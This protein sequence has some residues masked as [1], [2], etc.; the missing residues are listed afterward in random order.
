MQKRPIES[1]RKASI[2]LLTL[3]ILAAT[4]KCARTAEPVA[5]AIADIRV[6]FAGHYKLGHWTPIEMLLSAGE[7]AVQGDVE[8]IVPDGD[9]VPTRVV[10]R[11]VALKAGEKRWVRLCVKF[12]RPHAAIAVEFR[13]ADG[14][15]LAERTF[16]G[17][18]VPV[19]LGGSS[20]SGAAKLV[21]EIGSQ[22]DLGSSIR[23]SDEGEPEETAV[24]YVDDPAQLPDRWDGYDG[25]DLVVLTTSKP[26]FYRRLSV[27]ALE[28]SIAG[29]TS[30][31]AW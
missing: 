16:S 6:G 2:L 23:F 29:C 3:T 9:G 19:A 27:A 11:G 12:G 15:V 24:A 17:D 26:E 14:A 13:A 25:V 21:L 1:Q 28:R 5:L 7:R 10:E 31:A 20:K 18:E 30:A 8:V 22:L 4:A